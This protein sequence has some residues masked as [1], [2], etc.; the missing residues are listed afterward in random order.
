MQ[1]NLHNDPATA[2]HQQEDRDEQAWALLLQSPAL[3]DPDLVCRLLCVSRAMLEA[4]HLHLAGQL[5]V[6]VSKECR[7]GSSKHTSSMRPWLARHGSLLRSLAFR[8]LS[9]LECSRPEQQQQIAQIAAGLKEAAATAT[10]G[11]LRLTSLASNVCA[12][13]L[14]EALPPNL[15]RLELGPSCTD[16]LQKHLSAAAAA[17]ARSPSPSPSASSCSSSTIFP[18]DSITLPAVAA[19]QPPPTDSA[20]QQQGSAGQPPSS[21]RQSQQ[22]AAAVPCGAVLASLPVLG[23]VVLHGYAA[24]ALLCWLQPCT[25]LRSLTLC[26][27]LCPKVQLLHSLPAQLQVR[28]SSC[29]AGRCSQSC[30]AGVHMLQWS[31]TAGGV[32]KPEAVFGRGGYC[33]RLY[34][35]QLLTHMPQ[36]RA[37]IPCMLI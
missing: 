29:C 23:Q 35:Q 1:H 20:G 13:V 2:V 19:V 5:E 30:A 10:A 9:G 33:N 28:G 32:G 14:L 22:A 21:S 7:S 17:A 4:V 34:M 25:Q 8:Q 11:Q 31:H 18:T 6:A 37:L 24:N 36:G 16:E 26:N 3:A 15:T 12:K 27:L